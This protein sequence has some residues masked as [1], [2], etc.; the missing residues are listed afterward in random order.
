[1]MC[2][3]KHAFTLIELLVVIAIIAIL[4]AILLPAL[5][6]ARAKAYEADCQSNLRQLGTALVNYSSSNDGYFPEASDYANDQSGLLQKLSDF[7]PTNTP[8]WFCRA[9][10]RR[11]NR[12]I[13]NGPTNNE[14]GYFYWAW[15]PP[16]FAVDMSTTSNAWNSNVAFGSSLNTSNF[17]GQVWMSDRFVAPPTPEQYHGGRSYDIPLTDPGTHIL[18]GN[19]SVRKIAPVPGP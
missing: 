14:I 15:A 10:A 8:V 18:F 7:M 2:C 16:S 9:E 1:M 4:A 6:M 12:F 5:G 11:S 19:G 3:R 17:S 13:K